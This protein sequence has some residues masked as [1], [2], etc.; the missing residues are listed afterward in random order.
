MTSQR[1]GNRYSLG[2][3]TNYERADLP[4]SLLAG[5]KVLGQKVA[6]KKQQTDR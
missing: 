5:G 4:F 2:I 1:V 6:G 3:A